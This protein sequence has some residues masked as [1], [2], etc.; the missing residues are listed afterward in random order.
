MRGILTDKDVV[1]FQVAMIYASLMAMLKT[2]NQLQ[3]DLPHQIIVP[4][5]LS[6]PNRAPHVSTR[7]KVEDDVE[8][9]RVVKN[10]VK[11]DDILV[12]RNV[13]FGIVG[14]G[15]VPMDTAVVGDVLADI[16]IG[17]NVF[18]IAVATGDV[19]RDIVAIRYFITL[20]Y[21]LGHGI[22]ASGVG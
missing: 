11:L 4:P 2:V 17:V 7:E 16:F 9:L 6:S 1:R 21:L 12:T 15:R 13:Y 14:A 19:L 10:A 5:I 3:K 22:L 8:V 18:A 20:G